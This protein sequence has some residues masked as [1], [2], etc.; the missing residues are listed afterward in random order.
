MRRLHFIYFKGSSALNMWNLIRE[1]R[2]ILSVKTVKEYFPSN[3]SA[4]ISHKKHVFFYIKVNTHRPLNIY[5]A[6]EVLHEIR[7]SD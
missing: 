7:I 4:Y 2:D 5:E 6:F 1:I 3:S